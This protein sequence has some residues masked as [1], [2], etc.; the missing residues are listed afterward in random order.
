MSSIIKFLSKRVL[1]EK[2]GPKK[3]IL[4]ELLIEELSQVLVAPEISTH[5]DALTT[6]PKE[7]KI[8]NQTQQINLGASSEEENDLEEGG[9][10]SNQYQTHLTIGRIPILVH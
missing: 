2:P 9:S 1:A 10:S 4:C 8:N 3:Q 7:E 5:E 6:T